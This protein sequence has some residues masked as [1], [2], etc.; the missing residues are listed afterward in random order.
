[1]DLLS[2][3]E[4]ALVLPE[5][6]TDFRVEDDGHWVWSG[7]TNKWGYAFVGGK[8][9]AREIFTLLVLKG[10]FHQSKVL[11]RKCDVDACVNPAHMLYQNRAALA[12]KQAGRW[13]PEWDGVGCTHDVTC[14]R[15]GCGSCAG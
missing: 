7:P 14:G 15:C 11:E 10:P 1:M 6:L 2:A 8:N 13:L 9:V 12:A 3:W 4:A 5:H